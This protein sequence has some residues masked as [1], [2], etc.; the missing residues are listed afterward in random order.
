MTRCPLM[1][2]SR[3]RN[4]RLRL[5]P[6]CQAAL[7][8]RSTLAETKFHV[9]PSLWLK[10]EAPAQ[11][12]GPLTRAPREVSGEERRGT[13]IAQPDWSNPVPQKEKPRRNGSA[14]GPGSGQKN[15]AGRRPAP[16]NYSFRLGVLRVASPQVI[17]GP[18]IGLCS[19]IR[20]ETR[21]LVPR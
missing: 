7:N 9:Q 8:E 6:G 18:S 10:E 20:C 14:P 4:I 16:S 2:Q 13:L 11:G 3:P 15:G 1:T 5:I 17:A 12:P 19:I 21:S